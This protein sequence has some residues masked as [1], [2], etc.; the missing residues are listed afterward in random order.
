[1]SKF[2]KYSFFFFRK[3]KKKKN[4]K[5]LGIGQDLKKFE[6]IPMLE[7]LIYFFFKKKK[8]EIF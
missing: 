7:S 3:N 2:L 5:D 6:K 1:V 4:Y 8:I